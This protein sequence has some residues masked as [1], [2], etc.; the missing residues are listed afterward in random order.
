[1]RLLLIQVVPTGNSFMGD[2]ACDH[3]RASASSACAI[4]GE[5]SPQGWQRRYKI[6][7]V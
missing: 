5:A 6:A 4:S 7:N 1:M 3:T 2:G